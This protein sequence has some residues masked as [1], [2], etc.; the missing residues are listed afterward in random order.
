M[1]P[2]TQITILHDLNVE[3]K[4]YNGML[5]SKLS[6]D[7]ATLGDNIEYTMY[8]IVIKGMIKLYI[9]QSATTHNSYK[10]I[11]FMVQR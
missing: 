7:D 8:W 1:F 5:N 9:S 3:H 11:T 4:I 2:L 6:V 10:T